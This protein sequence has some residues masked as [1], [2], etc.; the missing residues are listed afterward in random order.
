MLFNS[1]TTTNS[2]VAKINRTTGANNT[3]YPL[4]DKASDVNEALD[5]YWYIAM[6]GDGNWQIDDSNNTDLPIAV[7]NLVSGQQDYSFPSEVMVIEKVFVKESGG[8]FKEILPIDITQDVAIWTSADS[9]SPFQYDKKANSIFLNYTPNYNST[10]GLKVVFK[11]GPSYFV[12]TDTTKAPG[13]PAIFHSYF[14]DYASSVFLAN[15]LSGSAGKL[16][17]L[18]IKIRNTEQ[19]IQDFYGQRSKDELKR[20]IPMRQNNK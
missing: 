1:G 4:A 5:K 6:L 10:G 8:N 11:R 15:K 20:F 17:R 9:G 3:T 7:T 13:V 18:L 19:A 16:D 14:S 12:S 2:I